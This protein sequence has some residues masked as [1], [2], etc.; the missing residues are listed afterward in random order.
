MG[1]ALPPLIYFLGL[2]LLKFF[3]FLFFANLIV[4][5]V[6]APMIAPPIIAGI[7]IAVCRSLDMILGDFFASFLL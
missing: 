6:A 7:A 4:A 1:V 3:V 2:L 5:A